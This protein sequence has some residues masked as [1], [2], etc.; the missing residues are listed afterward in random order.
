MSSKKP[1]SKKTTTTTA[2]KTPRVSKK[3]TPV[4]TEVVTPVTVAVVAENTQEDVNNV[5]KE[6]KVRQR[7]EVTKES[8]D[9]SFETL[10]QSVEEEIKKHRESSEKVKGVKFLRSINKRLKQIQN[11][12]RRVIT[13]KVPSK[14]STTRQESGFMKAVQISPEMLA[15]TGWDA[16]QKYSRVDVTKFICQY[17]KTH[18]LQEPKDRRNINADPALCKILN[19]DPVTAPVDE[20][21]T[22]FRIQRKIQPHFIKSPPAVVTSA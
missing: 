5:N 15:F 6:K 11:D 22:Y 12:A 7:R 13:K 8:I 1:S 10:R 18:D 3:S 16:N 2:T 19:W 9:S 21:L 20:P 4:V 17:I 14:R